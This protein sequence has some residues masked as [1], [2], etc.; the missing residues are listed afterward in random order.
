MSFRLCTE[1]LNSISA[2]KRGEWQLAL[3]ELNEVA[4]DTPP[5]L[6]R[7]LDDRT[8]G[9]VPDNDN[10]SEAPVTL[11]SEPVRRALVRYKRRIITFSRT[12]AGA[13]S[14]QPGTLQRLDADK[15]DAHNAGAET[16]CE[17]LAPRMQLSHEAS[18]HLFSL[19]YLIWDPSGGHD[20]RMHHHP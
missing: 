8:P 10:P 7:L 13:R 11:L 4:Q 3:E 6:I 9:L 19:L 14:I 2:E 16:L 1:L 5:T 12:C 17:V 15:R 18:R 20:I